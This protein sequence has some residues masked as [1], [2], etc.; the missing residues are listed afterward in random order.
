VLK[1]VMAGVV[2]PVVALLIFFVVIAGTD[3]P[4]TQQRRQD[5]RYVLVNGC[6]DRPIPH[7]VPTE[8]GSAAATW[9]QGLLGAEL[10]L[11]G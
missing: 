6:L 8:P 5:L 3:R 2:I 9:T 7:G 11:P 10:A 1:V 4:R